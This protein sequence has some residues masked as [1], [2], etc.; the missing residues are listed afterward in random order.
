MRFRRINLAKIVYSCP[1]NSVSYPHMQNFFYGIG[2]SIGYFRGDL[3]LLL[4][5]IKE[6]KPTL[7]PTV[8]RMLNRIYAEVCY[9]HSLSPSLSL[10][11]SHSLSLSHSL[12]GKFDTHILS[13]FCLLIIQSFIALIT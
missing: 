13:F 10:S 11:H 5:D 6:L 12:A 9:S 7:L 1:N 2:G 3:K 4:E 8:P